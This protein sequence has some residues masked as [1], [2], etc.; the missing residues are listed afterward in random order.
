MRAGLSFVGEEAGG[1]NSTTIARVL[2]RSYISNVV[3]PS[4]AAAEVLEYLTP[5]GI[6]MAPG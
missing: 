5:V 4:D 6:K 3:V 2:A 1:Q